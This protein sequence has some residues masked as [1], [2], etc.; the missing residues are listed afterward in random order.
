[1][2]TET[3]YCRG[4]E[5]EFTISADHEDYIPTECPY[6]GEWMKPGATGNVRVEVTVEITHTKLRKV[7]KSGLCE[8]DR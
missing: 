1:M 2:V 6:C 7:R 4:C 3:L 8:D 5:F